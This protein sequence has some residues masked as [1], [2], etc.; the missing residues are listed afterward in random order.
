MERGGRGSP[1]GVLGGPVARGP[2]AEPRKQAS[3]QARRG[4]H[5]Q[6]W[7]PVRVWG[8]LAQYGRQAG[9][10]S[11]KEGSRHG[12]ESTGCC[13]NILGVR[14]TEDRGGVL[15]A[16]ADHLKLSAEHTGVAGSLLVSMT[17]F[18][19]LKSHQNSF[20]N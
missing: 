7:A 20:K 14:V 5:A 9:R 10:Q 1:L 8:G 3:K 18:E 16:R 4:S 19:F 11:L 6:S 15:E 17:H 13:P 2:R 12:A